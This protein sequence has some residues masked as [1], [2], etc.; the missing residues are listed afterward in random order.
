MSKSISELKNNEKT[1]S[2]ELLS[3]LKEL[4]IGSNNNIKDI[5]LQIENANKELEYR[6]SL[7]ENI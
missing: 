6:R 4:N 7:G 1:L 2:S 5:Q 3:F